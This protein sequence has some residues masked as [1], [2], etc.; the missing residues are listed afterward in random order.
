MLNNG[1]A[2]LV[3]VAVAWQIATLGGSQEEGN[4]VDYF[5]SPT[6]P[7]SGRVWSGLV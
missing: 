3:I 6:T 5:S 2:V 7:R 1:G 4:T